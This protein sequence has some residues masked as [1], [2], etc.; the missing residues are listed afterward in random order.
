MFGAIAWLSLGF[1]TCDF[2]AS[3]IGR[4]CEFKSFFSPLLKSA[5]AL[6]ICSFSH[7][8]ASGFAGRFLRFLSSFIALA[9]EPSQH[10]WKPPSPLIAMILPCSKSSVQVLKALSP[11]A[12]ICPFKSFKNAF[13]P[14][15]G[16][17]V[18]WAWKRRF[19]GSLYSRS[20]LAH[21]LNSAM[22]V[23]LRS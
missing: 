3:T 18:G 9:F 13:G 5:K 16:Q 8:I 19:K 11:P 15:L 4:S 17:Q 10:R 1:K 21:I 23:F 22:L 20:Q 2:F 6:A 7:I 14:Q 12:K